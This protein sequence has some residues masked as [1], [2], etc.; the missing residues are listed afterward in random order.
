MLRGACTARRLP[1]STS[2]LIINRPLPS[3]NSVRHSIIRV[4]NTSRTWRKDASHLKG[5]AQTGPT[6]TVVEISTPDSVQK[7]KPAE[8]NKQ[9]SL[10]GEQ[11]VSNKE[12]RKA[13]WA[14]IKDM[15]RYLWP[16][17]DLGT[18]FRVSLSVAL[19]VG[20]KVDSTPSCPLN[21][22]R[23]D[24]RVGPKCPSPFLFQKHCRFYEHRFRCSWGH[25][26]DRCWCYNLFL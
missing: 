14:I 2:P 10:L 13:D 6:P 9:P 23:V 18:R 4:I 17:N 19:L 12:Q 7:E 5:T 20:A 16:K 24:S 21:R 8:P 22:R 15:A 26:H 1:L 11:T 25:C 3:H